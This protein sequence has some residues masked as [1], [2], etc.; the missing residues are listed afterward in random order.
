MENAGEDEILGKRDLLYFQY[1]VTRII[2]ETNKFSNVYTQL[3]GAIGG[4]LGRSKKAELKTSWLNPGE[5]YF[6]SLK[7]NNEYVKYVFISFN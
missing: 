1:G 7:V 2:G 6:F 3:K 4:F 5:I